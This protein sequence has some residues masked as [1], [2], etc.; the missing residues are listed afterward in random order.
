VRGAAGTPGDAA[1]RTKAAR[2]AAVVRAVTSTAVRSQ[3]QLAGLLADAGF[4]ATQATLSRDLDDLG[5]VKTRHADGTLV[6]AVPGQG[7]DPSPVSAV[8]EATRDTRLARRCA[9][10]LLSAE[11]SANLVVVR[12]PPG[13]AQFLA[14]ALD[15]STLHDPR[16]E[17]LGTIAGDDTILVITRDPLG[18][19]ATA[20]RLADLA[21]SPPRAAGP[22]DAEEGS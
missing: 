10:L 2:Q 21:G 8:D 19:E 13:A 7:G 1:V 17:I 12:T 15:R 11:G 14:S 5:A 3:A 9:E 4:E 20:R 18:G 16:R 6:Y 22:H